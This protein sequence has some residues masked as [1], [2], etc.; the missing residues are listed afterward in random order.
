MSVSFGEATERLLSGQKLSWQKSGNAIAGSVMLVTSRQRRLFQYLLEA[1]SQEVAEGSDSLFDGLIAAWRDENSDPVP[2]ASDVRPHTNDGPWYLHQIKTTNFGGLNTY[3]GPDFHLILANENWCLEGSN[4]SGK[5]ALASAIAWAL[6]GYRLREHDGLQW[7]SGVRT[8]VYDDSGRKIGDWPPI[9]TYP[10]SAADLKKAATVSVELIFSNPSREQAVAR[11]TLV[12]SADGEPEIKVDVDGRLMTTPQLIETGLLMPSRLAHIGFGAKSGSLYDAMKMLT[13]LDQLADISQGAGAFTNKGRR[14][15]K[16]AKDR[17]IDRLERSFSDDLAKARELAQETQLTIAENLALG[18][19]NLAEQLQKLSDTASTEAG[20]FLAILKSDITEDV[21]LSATDGRKKLSRA[22]NSA[23]DVIEQKTKGIPLF[24]AWAALKTASNDQAFNR[25]RSELTN[26]EAKL[27]A[28]LAWHAN[29]LADEK[30]R[31]KALASRFFLP[32]DELTTSSV[33]PL[34]AQNLE[35]EDQRALA[36][37]LSILKENAD[38]AER[39]IDDAC[40]DIDKALRVLLPQSIQDHFERLALMD[41]VEDYLAAI[42]DRFVNPEPFS[43]ILVGVA[44]SVDE[45]I[46]KQFHALPTFEFSEFRPSEVS[47]PRAASELR[48]FIHSVGRVLALTDWWAKHRKAFVNAWS[49]LLGEADATGKFSPD[50]LEG[51]VRKLEEASDKANPLDNIASHLKEAKKTATAWN[52]INAEQKM[53]EDIADAL[54]PLKKLRHLVDAE[55]H[56]TID[57]LSERVRSILVEIRLKERLTF[58]NAELQRRQVSVHG[59]FSEDYKIDAGLV[60]NASWLRAVLWAF[61]F[62]MRDETIQEEG[63]CSFPLVVLDDPQLTFDPKN[64]RKW[65]QKIVE[66]ANT[67]RTESNGFQLFLATHERQF[68]DII[69]TTCGL[70]GQIGMI[71]RPHGRTDVA[72]IL[73]GSKLE[74]QYTEAHSEQCDDKGRKYVREVRVYCEDLLRIM[75]RPESY[76]LTT[77]TLGALTDLLTKHGQNKIAPFDRPVFKKLTNSLKENSDPAIVYMN[78]SSHTDDG[79]IGLAE[80]E[81]VERYWTKTLKRLF[82]DAF[83]V[84]ADYDAYAGDPR[85]YTYRDTVIEFPTSRPSRIAQANLL[86]TGMAAAATSDGYIGDGAISIEEW[87]NA[88]SLK[89]HNHDAY[90]VTA[91]TLEPVVTIGD[92]LL[93]KNYGDP[94]ARNLIV[95]AYGDGFV[96]RRLNLSDDHPGMAVLTGQS[97]NPYMLPQPII[98]PAD[99]LHMRR[100]VGT[101]FMSDGK[102]LPQTVGEVV[103]MDDSAAVAGILEGARLFQVSGRSM[104]PIALEEQFVITRLETVDERTLARLEGALVIAVD[105]SGAKYFKRLRRRD[106]LIILES[107]NSD[108]RTPSELLSLQGHDRP[109]LASLFSVAGVLFEEP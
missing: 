86:K 65:A 47:E 36:A 61:I 90:R 71:A 46:A 74:R 37:E 66:L 4:G 14:F 42:R 3:G 50:S 68:F 60:A 83:K 48:V 19:K 27:E 7:E 79:T 98:S 10:L 94:N 25:L 24:A 32:P 57:S 39:A 2:D 29:Q 91:S 56:R 103:P 41:P 63:F 45:Q 13:G 59:H 1:K 54:D 30:L 99:K 15:L 35:T 43:D 102:P 85:L 96:A 73:N 67:D 12:S 77:N 108:A 11:R 16:Y 17:G 26:F 28:A 84:A 9:T 53:R 97:T 6:T 93:V 52:E 20:K 21:D 70:D 80:A 64:K 88:D 69:T 87:E 5:T 104:E 106:D 34:C 100:V 58:G 38:A 49:T 81:D 109:A 82:S 51:M 22:V 78:A 55:T 95:A 107:A 18:N 44:R 75:L 92:V 76:E 72:Q 8:P 40:S 89:L 105:E 62:A 101:V 23:R 31:L 33:C